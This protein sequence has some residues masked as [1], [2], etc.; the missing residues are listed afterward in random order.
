MD[1]PMSRYP[2]LMPTAP[3]LFTAT[4]ARTEAVSPS[5]QRVTITGPDLADFEWL[6]RDHWFRL[7]LPPEPGAPLRLPT[8]KGRSWYRSYLLIPS[9]ERPHCSNYTV[10]GLRRDGGVTELDIDVVLHWHD[11]HLGGAVATWAVG[12]EVGSPV[13]LLDQGVMFDPPEDAAEIVLASDETGLP[14]LRGILRDLDQDVR[15]AAF[16]EVPDA[17]DVTDIAAPPGIEVRWLVRNGSGGVPGQ[18]ALAAIH[19]HSPSP[20]AYAFVVGESS[21]ATGGRKA[22]KRA[23]V[24]AS[25]ITFSGFW[26]A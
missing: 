14:G 25:R 21:L 24:P 9:A 16:L 17:G 15:G 3:R 7:F 8:V 23:G 4:V 26:R 18:A 13:G 12:A 1:G 19:A 6:G 2:R 20:D 5:F 11:G 22:L 10:A